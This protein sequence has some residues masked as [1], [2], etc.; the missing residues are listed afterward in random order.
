MSIPAR[1]EPTGSLAAPARP[2]RADVVANYALGVEAYDEL[3]SPVILSPAAG[4]VSSLRLRPGSVVLDVGAGTGALTP[5]IRSTEPG[6]LVISLDATWEMLR[7]A[8][9]R[10]GAAAVL[11]DAQALPVATGTVD[12]V[13]LAYVLFHLAEPLRALQEAARVLRPAGRVGTVTWQSERPARA[14]LVWNDALAEAGVSPLS[15]RRV[16]SGLDSP[17]A[18]AGLLDAAGFVPER[19]W[20]SPLHHEWDRVSF[21]SL[22]TGI[23]ANRR[24]LHLGVRDDAAR[25]A[26]LADLWE[27]VGRLHAQDY[28]WEGTVVCAV[29]VKPRAAAR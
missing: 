6:A 18:V 21:W 22:V 4:L 9:G 20:A 12:A 27:R 14:Q 16:D 5:A 15:T 11:A 25:S 23:G 29:G 1:T 2:R 13:V 10:R 3:W 8:H 7:V 24:Q 17:S 28:R 26:L 19:V